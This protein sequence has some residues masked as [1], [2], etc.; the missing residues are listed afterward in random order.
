MAALGATLPCSVAVDGDIDR[1]EEEDD[2]LDAIAKLTRNY[3]NLRI[4][5][6]TCG[7]AQGHIPMCIHMRACVCFDL[8]IKHQQFK[9]T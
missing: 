5:F 4:Y 2:L 8:Q 9:A 1:V 7:T 6:R 3:K